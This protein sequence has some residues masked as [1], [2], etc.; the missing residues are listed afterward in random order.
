MVALLNCA[1]DCNQIYEIMGNM[2]K[3]LSVYENLLDI[4]TSTREQE[5]VRYVVVCD[6]LLML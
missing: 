5:T 1:F 6:L 3:L 2:D 4:Y